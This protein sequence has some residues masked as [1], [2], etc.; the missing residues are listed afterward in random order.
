VNSVPRLVI[1]LELLLVSA[2][3]GAEPTAAQL[4]RAVRETAADPAECYRVRDLSFAKEDI[5]LYL[6]EGY[7]I[8]SKPIDGRRVW[9]AFSSDVDGG[10]GEVILFPPTRS[11]RQS[12]AGFTQSPNL[13]EHLRSAFMVFTDGTAE[14]LLEQIQRDGTGRRAPE[15]G[16]ATAAEWSPIAANIAAPMQMRLVEDILAPA[17]EGSLVFL[18]LGGK[19]LGTFDIL[20]DGREGNQ[21]VARQRTEHNGKPAYDVWTSFPARSVRNGNAVGEREFTLSDYRIDASLDALL[22]VQAVTKVTVRVGAKARRVFSFA[23]ANAMQVRSVKIDGV[24]VEVLAG[25]SVRGRIAGVSEEQP[26][27]IVA[28]NEIAAGSQHEFEFEHLGNVIT[29]AG[30]NVYFVNARGSWYPH[31]GSGAATFDLRF[32]YPRRLTLV[33]AGDPVDDRLDGDWRVTERRISVPVSSA[34][35]NL[36]DYE[37]VVTSA[38]GIAIDVYGNRHVEDSLRP[39]VIYIPIPSADAT[40]GRG[41]GRGLAAPPI[42]PIPIMPPPPDPLGRLKAVAADMSSSM[43]FYANLFGP[44]AIKHVTVAPIPGTF[45]QGFPGLVYMSTIAY[46][47]PQDRPAALRSAREQAFYSDLIVPHEAAHQWWGAVVNIEKNNDA[48]LLEGLANYSALMWLEKKRSPKE[49]QTILDRYRG[50][51]LDDASGK[52][53]PD[54]AGPI[55]WGDRLMAS[56]VP[57][58]WRAITYAKGTWILHMLRKRLGDERFL[59]MLAELR[60]RYEFKILTTEG[61]RALAVEFRPKGVSAEVMETFFDNWVYSSGIPSLKLKSS[62]KPGA[63]SVALTGTLDQTGVDDDFSVDVPLDV[64]FARGVVQTIWVRSSGGETPFSATLRQL[65]S[66]VVISDDIL[67]KK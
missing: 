4:A 47:D 6:N 11:E 1:L 48:W 15:I 34:G 50:E 3:L 13:D 8:F 23:I 25:D 65:P 9:A 2:V 52:G 40:M 49:M 29:S 60:K 64:Q 5:R 54:S 27:L 62:A 44:P 20:M 22:H 58:A 7:L 19:S 39:R 67:T 10:D 66:R 41:R 31:I 46:L 59:S 36:G 32:R 21:I 56:E 42:D 53:T 26:L 63:A 24:P 35:F 57:D 45:G 43:E 18:A 51:L 55:V 61:F 37:K 28:P 30:D 14:R 12:L 38:P 17:R 16:A 33:T